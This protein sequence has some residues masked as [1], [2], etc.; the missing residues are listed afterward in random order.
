MLGSPMDGCDDSAWRR[1]RDE[2]PVAARSWRKR[3][4]E[5]E[6]ER[7]IIS[8]HGQHTTV[9]VLRSRQAARELLDRLDGERTPADDD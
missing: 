3:R 7:E 8:R 9:H 5:P 2:W 4:S 6:R 1:L